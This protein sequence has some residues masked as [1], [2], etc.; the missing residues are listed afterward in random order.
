MGK[1]S[2][3][4]ASIAAFVPSAS[5]NSYWG[6]V[7]YGHVVGISLGHAASLR[8]RRRSDTGFER[9][10]ADLTPRSL[11]HLSDE[12]RHQWEHS[13]APIEQPRWSIKFRSL[14]DQS[15]RA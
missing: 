10:R 15:G 13:V 6:I 3:P 2:L 12:V 5:I 1:A 9:A 7:R 11:Y 4:S 8:L 14:A